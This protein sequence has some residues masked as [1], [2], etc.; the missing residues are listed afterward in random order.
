VREAILISSLVFACSAIASCGG[1]SSENGNKPEIPRSGGGGSGV[2]AGTGGAATA[3][4]G[5]SANSGGLGGTP[6]PPLVGGYTGVGGLAGAAGQPP[7]ASEA[8]VEYCRVQSMAGCA[9]GPTMDSCNTVTCD[10]FP[11]A[12][13]CKSQYYV[14]RKCLSAFGSSAF[15]CMADGRVINKTDVCRSENG[16]LKTCLGL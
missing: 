13:A 4:G 10:G 11:K 8:C 1:G 16:S 12:E 14:L 15:E 7:S 5:G 3:M 6:Q 2:A 9:M